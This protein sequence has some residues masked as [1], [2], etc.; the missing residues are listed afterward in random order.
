LPNDIKRSR[1]QTVIEHTLHQT[2]K[3]RPQSASRLVASSGARLHV[4]VGV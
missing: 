4:R 3:R 1:M 2:D